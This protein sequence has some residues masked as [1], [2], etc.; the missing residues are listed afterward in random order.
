[1]GLANNIEI[2]TIEDK[3]ILDA[4]AT[5]A[6]PPT[7]SR[8]DRSPARG[9]STIVR[10]N[11][12][13]N[14]IT[15]RYRL[16]DTADEGAPRRPSR[17]ATSSFPPARCCPRRRPGAQGNRDARSPWPALPVGAVSV[18]TIDVDLPRIAIYTTWANTE[19]VGWVRLA[20]DRF[21]IPFDLIHK[22]H[23]QSRR[24]PARQYDVIVMPHQ[25]QNGKSIVYEQPKLRSRCPTRKTRSSNHWACTPKPKM[26]AAAWG[27]TA[28]PS[29][30]S[31]STRRPAADLRCRRVTSRR[32]SASRRASMRRVPPRA[33]THRART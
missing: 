25:T 20:F 29:S 28:R 30:R 5:R 19:K 1:M 12:A 7:W 14:L 17:S 6:R 15:L 33:G 32:S 22:D 10:H 11:G 31:S 18:Q 8:R 4:A 3:T 26:S 23:V 13:L 24:E 27:S 2:K 9:R 21:E 16:K